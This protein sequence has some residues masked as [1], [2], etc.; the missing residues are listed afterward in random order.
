MASS[1]ISVLYIRMMLAR[2]SILALGGLGILITA[3]LVYKQIECACM[4]PTYPF[5]ELPACYAVLVFFGLVVLSQHVSKHSRALFLTGTILGL[6]T[7]IWFSINQVIG[8]A[9]CPKFLGIPLCFVAALTFFVLLFIDS[10]ADG[11]RKMKES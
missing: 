10:L 9:E 3:W 11:Q 8:A 7:A 2:K 4:C 6:I 5:I 1:L